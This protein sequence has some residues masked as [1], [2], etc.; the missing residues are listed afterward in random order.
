MSTSL[1]LRRVDVTGN[2]AKSRGQALL[3]STGIQPMTTPGLPPIGIIVYN[4][5]SY[6]AGITV[7]PIPRLFISGTD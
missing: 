1:S 7:T 4:G 3:T 2:Y 5:E 6:G